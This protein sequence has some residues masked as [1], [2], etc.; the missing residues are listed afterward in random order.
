MDCEANQ[1]EKQFE[2]QCNSRSNCL[3]RNSME[4]SLTFY[5]FYNFILGGRRRRQG[6]FRRGGKRNQKVSSILLAVLCNLE[7]ED[8]E[9]IWY[10]FYG[11]SL[12]RENPSGNRC[13]EM[14]CLFYSQPEWVRC[15]C[16]IVPIWI[17][18]QQFLF[19]TRQCYEFE[20]QFKFEFYHSENHGWRCVN[21][22]E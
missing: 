20:F 17:A 4:L 3:F 14:A 16:W 8:E 22:R 7:N 1:I 10:C 19:R 18:N 15:Y 21:Y 12:E 6:R 11:T 2:K 5:L 13:E 9:A